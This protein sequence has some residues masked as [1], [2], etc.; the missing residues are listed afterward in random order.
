MKPIGTGQRKSNETVGTSLKVP[1]VA[2]ATVL[3]LVLPFM[4]IEGTN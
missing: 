4:G 1:A 3:E 2:D